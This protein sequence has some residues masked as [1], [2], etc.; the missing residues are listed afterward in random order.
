MGIN[1]TE[2]AYGFG[3]LGSA[4]CDTATIV[5]PPAGKVIIAVYFIQDNVPTALVAEDPAMY[6]NTVQTAHEQDHADTNDQDHGDGGLTLSAAN[7]KGGTTIFGRWT[8]ITPA[9]DTDGGVIC[10]FGE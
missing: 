6:F 3:Q 2:V 7:F 1:S 9:A 10:Y 4:Y 5:T 8:S